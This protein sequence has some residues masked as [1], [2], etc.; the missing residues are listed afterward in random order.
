[1]REFYAYDGFCLCPLNGTLPD[2]AQGAASPFAPLVF[3]IDRDPHT[4]RGFF[5]ISSLDELE[6][7]EGPSLLL[8]VKARETG[9]LADFV[10]E[11]GAAVL[12]TAF[13]RAFCVLRD[14]HARKK[15]PLRLTLVGLGDVGG[16]LLTGLKLLGEGIGEIGI[17]DPNQAQCARYEMELNQVLPVGSAPLAPIVLR[18]E[19]ALFD[20]DALL[21]TASRGVPG[22]DS[23]VQDVRMAQYEANKAML[24]IYARKAREAGF[25][26]LFCQ[27]SDPVDHLARAV[28]L[29]SNTLDGTF[30]GGGLLP[31]QVQGYGLGVMRAR[32]RYYAERMGIDASRLCAFGPHGEGLIVANAPDEEYDDALS[33]ALTQDA[34]TANLKVR[35]LGFKPYIAPGLSSACV[36][37]LRTL[38]GEWHDG[39]APLG[40]AY[41]GCQT[42]FTK[43]GPAQLRMPLCAPLYERICATYSALKEFDYA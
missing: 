41:F 32:A 21:F 14:F 33:Q 10:K 31:E 43:N 22:L 17:Y 30:D 24:A 8:P 34:R 42:R 27:I 7:A 28:F 5:A 29:E 6:E 26:G 16:T 19:G 38:R 39:A 18:E 1:M 40:G 2:G 11:N 37:V 15:R 25:T 12:N 36:S 3:L 20:C 35:A 9:A 4:A 13:S 23:Q